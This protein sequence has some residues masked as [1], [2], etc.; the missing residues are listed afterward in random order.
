MLTI[1]RRLLSFASFCSG[2]SS[3]SCSL[4]IHLL[5][6]VFPFIWLSVISFLPSFLLCYFFSWCYHHHF[7]IFVFEVNGPFVSLFCVQSVRFSLVFIYNFWFYCCFF[8]VIFSIFLLF[9]YLFCPCSSALFRWFWL[10]R[11]VDICR[12]IT[13]TSRGTRS[14]SLYVVF[15]SA[16]R[17]PQTRPAYARPFLVR[18]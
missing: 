15:S 3:S 5:V 14:R 12:Y 17:A 13:C 9:W 7:N 6:L 16:A 8:H 2:C 4:L 1:H 11:S 18:S 10:F